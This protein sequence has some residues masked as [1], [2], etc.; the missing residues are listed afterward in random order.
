M[1]KVITFNNRLFWRHLLYED[2][3]YFVTY[4][5]YNKYRIQ[6]GNFNGLRFDVVRR[7]LDI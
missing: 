6:I 1:E 3:W 5:P 2:G 4:N 7:W